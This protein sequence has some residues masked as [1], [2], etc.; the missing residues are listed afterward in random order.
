[1]PSVPLR[2]NCVAHVLVLH[3]LIVLSLNLAADVADV[4]GWED[5]S[6]MDVVRVSSLPC[7][8]T[9]DRPSYRIALSLTMS[10][11]QRSQLADDRNRRLALAALRFCLYAVPVRPRYQQFSVSIVTLIIPN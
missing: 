6:L 1:M 5:D 2:K 11:Q 3:I 4:Q 9:E 8:V 7:L 10:G